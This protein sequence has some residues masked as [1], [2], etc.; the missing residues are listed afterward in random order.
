MS[1]KTIEVS[2]NAVKAIKSLG[3]S[4]LTNQVGGTLLRLAAFPR[5]AARTKKLKGN[6]PFRVARCGEYR[7]LF[8][9]SG[10]L[11]RVAAFG[12]RNDASVYKKAQ[13]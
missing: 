12:K 10:Q 4:K 7:I 6:L 8:T 11:I 1:R 2:A 9:Q 5:P 3:S 13:K